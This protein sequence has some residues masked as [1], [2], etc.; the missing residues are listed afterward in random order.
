MS[1]TKKGNV[2]VEE[3]PTGQKQPLGKRMLSLLLCK[4][5][6]GSPHNPV[7]AGNGKSSAAVV[8]VYRHHKVERR[9]REKMVSNSN[10]IQSWQS[11]DES[12]QYDR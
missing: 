5:T 1:S 2:W 10:T 12:F 9:R 11:I 3:I 6:K 7:F 8:Q 4:K